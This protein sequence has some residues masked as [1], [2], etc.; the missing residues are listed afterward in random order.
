MKDKSTAYIQRVPSAYVGE[1]CAQLMFTYDKALRIT[2]V[3]NNPNE[4][5]QVIFNYN[6]YVRNSEYINEY[7]QDERR[8]QFPYS[9][10]PIHTERK[11]MKKRNVVNQLL[12][13]DTLYIVTRQTEDSFLR[14]YCQ[15]IKDGDSAIVIQDNKLSAIFSMTPEELKHYGF[16]KTPEPNIKKRYN[17]GFTQKEIEEQKQLV[18]RK[19]KTNS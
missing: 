3:G 19:N 4:E 6:E 18:K 13:Y 15:V 17:S 7:V 10:I 8:K 14:M 16:L 5:K 11:N 1:D 12:D 2:K 9:N